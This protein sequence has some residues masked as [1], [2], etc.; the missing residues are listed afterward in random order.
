MVETTT[1]VITDGM[2]DLESITVQNL[3]DLV[4]NIDEKEITF[5]T[6]K[7]EIFIEDSIKYHLISKKLGVKQLIIGRDCY[8]TFNFKML[9]NGCEDNWSV[10]LKMNVEEFLENHQTEYQLIYLL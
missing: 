10:R 3:R 5:Y 8:P 9:F 7:R 2:K 1:D 4:T 6:W